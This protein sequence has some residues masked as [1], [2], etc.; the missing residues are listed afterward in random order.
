AHRQR[1]ILFST[2]VMQHAERLCD[3][4][5]LIARGK[6]IFDGTISEARGLLPRRVQLET[7]DDLSPLQS[8][9]DVVSVKQVP[10]VNGHANGAPHWELEL[11]RSADPQLILQCC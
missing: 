5:L 6:K 4:I 3:R 10:V 8:L 11:C 1:T 7:E 2:H 9:Q